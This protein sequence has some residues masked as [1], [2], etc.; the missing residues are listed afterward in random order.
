VKSLAGALAIL[1]AA[2]GVAF[3][4]EA[5]DRH[6]G[7]GKQ[8]TVSSEPI[9]LTEQQLDNV[10][11]GDATMFVNVYPPNPFYPPN[12]Y[13]PPNPFQ[14]AVPALAPIIEPLGEPVLTQGTPG[15]V[16]R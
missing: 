16:T 15:I 12:P 6:E 5:T 13:R 2:A 3:A 10:V 7:Y 9:K 4:E 8:V 14:I 11:A 1:G